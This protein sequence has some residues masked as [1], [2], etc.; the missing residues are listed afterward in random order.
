MS[1]GK[2]RYGLDYVQAFEVRR[3]HGAAR[4]R[5]EEETLDEIGGLPVSVVREYLDMDGNIRDQW[6]DQGLAET[7][8]PL[9][10]PVGEPATSPSDE[11]P[12]N[13]GKS[14]NRNPSWTSRAKDARANRRKPSLKA[15]EPHEGEN[16]EEEEPA[17]NGEI[18]IGRG[19]A[20]IKADLLKQV[21][22]IDGSRR[23]LVAHK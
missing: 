17:F 19:T 18:K 12:G 13:K 7:S 15:A 5:S 10:P 6:L 2:I 9:V 23:L 20:R 16:E 1:E 21:S 14:R 3:P 4:G 8:Q 22:R 11:A